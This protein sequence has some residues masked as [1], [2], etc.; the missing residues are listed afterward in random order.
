[1]ASALPAA[2]PPAPLPPG[3]GPVT[4][5]HIEQETAARLGPFALLETASASATA[6]NVEVLKSTI[7]LGGWV[8]LHVL[9]REATRPEDRQARVKAY[10]PVLGQLQVDRSYISVPLPSEPLE[11]HHLEPAL[12]R[13]GVRAGLRRCYCQFWLTLV[14]PDPEDPDAPPLPRSGPVDLTE[15]SGGWLRLPQQVLDVVDAESDAAGTAAGSV[16]GWRAYGHNGRAYLLL[17]NGAANAGLSVIATRDHFSLVDGQY[18]PDGPTEDD[19][20]LDLDLTYGAALASIELWRIARP[21]LEAVAAEARQA[22]QAE[23]AAEATRLAVANAPWLFLPGSVRR[24]RIA[25][26]YGLTGATGRV[27][28]PSL[29]G[30]WVNGPDGTE[31]THNATAAPRALPPGRNG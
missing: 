19:H 17:P 4:L 21:Q 25:P 31:P 29:Q 15:Y 9:R 12:L 23:C 6:V 3:P 7:D 5:A 28:A 8:D 16:A 10:D 20:V 11:L 24:D 1:M 13:R 22:T 30:A 14:E 18:A 2:A 27:S 26:L